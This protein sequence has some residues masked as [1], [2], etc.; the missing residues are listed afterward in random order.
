MPT[1]SA[2]E[3]ASQPD[4][5]S[6]LSA[7]AQDTLATFER[8][9]SRARSV[10]AP[11]QRVTTAA[12]IDLGG[13][14][15]AAA[16]AELGEIANSTREQYEQICKEPAVARLLICDEEG[17]EQTLYIS[18][19][20]V[21]AGLLPSITVANYL[22]PKGRLAAA[23]MGKAVDVSL[24]LGDQTYKVL[25][26]ASL[27]PVWQD[28]D[29]DSVDTVFEEPCK[30]AL[31]I[32]SLRA[33]INAVSLSED[34]SEFIRSRSV[35]GMPFDPREDEVDAMALL[36]TQLFEDRKSANEFEG[37][38]R[39]IIEKMGF[40]DRPVLDAFQDDIFRLP[41][42]SRLVILGPPGTGKTTTL[43]KR[44]AQK[45]SWNYL[46]PEEQRLVERSHVRRENHRAS[47]LMFTPTELLRLY[48]KE[49]FLNENVPAS[50]GNIM[51]WDV[52]RLV[53]ARDRFGLLGS[54]ARAGA[55]INDTLD[56]LQPETIVQQR[57]W[58][59]DFD[60]WQRAAFFN[61]LK[62]PA[63]LLLSSQDTG[64]A[65]IGQRLRKIIEI[66]SEDDILQT[67][68]RFNTLSDSASEA[69]NRLR[70]VITE[71]L[72]R[73]FAL[74]LS[75]DRS[76]L[77]SLLSFLLTL[78][79]RVQEDSEEDNYSE[80]EGLPPQPRSRED[81]FNA[82]VD[83][84][85]GVSVARVDGRP[86]SPR[87]KNGRIAAWLEN[88]IPADDRLLTIGKLQKQL[89]ALRRFSNPFKSY[90]DGLPSRYRRFRRER[91]AAGKLYRRPSNGSSDLHPLEVDLLLYCLIDFGQRIMDHPAAFDLA[92]VRN[93]PLIE[94]LRSVRVNQILIDEVAD[95]SPIQIACMAMLCDPQTASVVAC[96]DLNQRI[97]F[98]G[99]RSRNDLAW[100]L[101]GL[102]VRDVKISYRHSGEIQLFL[103]SLL[104][105]SGLQQVV[106]QPH[107]FVDNQGVRPALLLDASGPK[108]VEWLAGRI[109]DIG[110]MVS[111]LPIPSIAVLVNSESDVL[112]L[113][114]E[115]DAALRRVNIRCAA[116]NRGQVKGNDRD[117]R[118]FDVQHV[119]GLEFESVFFVGIDQLEHN[120]PDLFEKYLYVGS[121]RAAVYLGMTCAGPLL[122]ERIAGLKSHFV[123]TWSQP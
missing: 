64:V 37:I 100:A 122:P 61:D 107:E 119:K 70:K 33:L 26:R 22:S 80:E 75:R 96:G 1:I 29:W 85:R 91:M 68:E 6:R 86:L 109:E 103:D 10:L 25:Q 89:A 62:E 42:N 50:D 35:P 114:V 5:Q 14:N 113:A 36:Q 110:R 71:T 63:K 11:G 112:P 87:S 46:M 123:S 60:A 39:G 116:C 59:E 48:V 115:L 57:A 92:Q 38:R 34:C 3:P 8:I 31:T 98:W 118:V 12:L 52:A 90:G 105:E 84:M 45:V 20:A 30:R 77:D 24:P 2:P 41:L 43:I 67:L 23:P 19:A 21:P 72:R 73:E 18:R 82:Y 106:I 58:L 56:N 94:T 13:T 111:P 55:I 9:A 15:G 4:K 17:R 74:Q 44:L 47:W 102:I 99:S 97:T 69:A 117:V 78:D 93:L 27:K 108:L 79:E 88:R 121:T 32:R 101:P 81:A 53:L 65:N 7:I 95:F 120:A 104:K 76:L 83:A 51:T 28:N 66:S 54:A 16:V 40:R 49:A